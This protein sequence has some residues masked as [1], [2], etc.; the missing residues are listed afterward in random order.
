MYL[1]S[2]L[3][4]QNKKAFLDLVI[5]AGIQKHPHSNCS[6]LTALLLKYNLIIID[7]PQLLSGQILNVI[8]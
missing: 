3:P 6:L 8:V 4:W 2:P 5:P 7:K 1:R